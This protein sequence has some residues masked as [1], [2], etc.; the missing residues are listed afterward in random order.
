MCTYRACPIFRKV[1][2]ICLGG[3]GVIIGETF[4]CFHSYFR[5]FAWRSLI[6]SLIWPMQVLPYLF[7]ESVITIIFF[8]LVNN[9]SAWAKLNTKMG[10]HPN[11]T[12]FVTSSRRRMT[13]NLCMQSWNNMNKTL[14][15]PHSRFS[16][17]DKDYMQASSSISSSTL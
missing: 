17:L 16:P 9:C 8:P 10:L 12:N 3:G 7:M 1:Y 5:L 15:Y 11:H 6:L 4:Y 13:L 14:P 2:S